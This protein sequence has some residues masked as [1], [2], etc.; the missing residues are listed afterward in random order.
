VYL[1]FRMIAGAG[2]LEGSLRLLRCGNVSGTSGA[3]QRP[4]DTLG[5]RLAG[6]FL[7][8]KY[9]ML[10]EAHERRTGEIPF[11]ASASEPSKG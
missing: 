9:V 6:G 2:T 11:K 10:S 3:R 7:S 1:M 5:R 4:I 8:G